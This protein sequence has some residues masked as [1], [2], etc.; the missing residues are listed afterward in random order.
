MAEID[1]QSQC[2]NRR[3]LTAYL[4][5]SRSVLECPAAIAHTVR[6]YFLS[7]LENHHES[8]LATT[9]FPGRR[10]LEVP[11]DNCFA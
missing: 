11:V 1:R 6:V 10:Q 2:I 9:S 3:C 4:D 5:E 8:C 7:R